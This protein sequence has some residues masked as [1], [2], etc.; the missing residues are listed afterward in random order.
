MKVL[1]QQK[2]NQ[3]QQ[4]ST[5]PVV[6]TGTSATSNTSSP[7][8]TSPNTSTSNI[9]FSPS[10]SN[11]SQHE[12]VGEQSKKRPHQEVESSS[13]NGAIHNDDF[14]PLTKSQKQSQQHTNPNTSSTTSNLYGFYNKDHD[15]DEEEVPTTIQP[16]V[17]DPRIAA[18]QHQPPL[19]SNTSQD[20]KPSPG[21]STSAPSST[22]R[23]TAPPSKV[24]LFSNLPPNCQKSELM[25]FNN[26]PE[27]KF[28]KVFLFKQP[29][30]GG[31][32]NSGKKKKREGYLAFVEFESIEKAQMFLDKFEG[33]KIKIRGRTAY[34]KYSEKQHLELTP[35]GATS[36]SDDPLRDDPTSVSKNVANIVNTNNATILHITFTHCD[37]Y[38]YPMHVDILFNLF[39][40]FGTLEKINIFV[41]NE[42]TQSLIQFSTADEATDALKEMEGKYVFPDMELYRMNIQFS[43]KYR[44]ELSIKENNDRN[45]DYTVFP[46]RPFESQPLPYGGPPY[47]PPESEPSYPSYPDS[48]G[49][50]KQ[51]LNGEMMDQSGSRRNLPS[52]PN[53]P[54]YNSSLP[55]YYPPFAA[56]YNPN[57]NYGSNPTYYPP[58]GMVMP[59]HSFP[60]Q[61][62]DFMPPYHQLGPP[63]AHHGV[64]QPHH[65]HPQSSF[66]SY[67]HPNALPPPVPMNMPPPSMLPPGSSVVIVKGLPSRCTCDHL[68]I[69]FGLYGDVIKVSI[70]L[71]KKDHKTPHTAFIQFKYPHEAANALRF[72]GAPYHP[73]FNKYSGYPPPSMGGSTLFGRTLQIEPSLRIFDI[74]PPRSK[75]GNDS[76]S[77][78]MDVVFRSYENSPLHR[79]TPRQGTQESYR[80]NM[81]KV[82]NICP[83]SPVLHI[84]N[85]SGTT[86]EDKIRREIDRLFD[87]DTSEK[88]PK[89]R[90]TDFKFIDY[91]KTQ[92]SDHKLKEK[93]SAIIE[94]ESIDS[95]TTVLVELHD[96][97]IDS[98][99]LNIKFSNRTGSTPPPPFGVQPYDYGYPQPLDD[100]GASRGR[101]GSSRGHP[102]DIDSS[103]PSMIDDQDN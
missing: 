56:G 67:S 98:H 91:K 10:S 76:N 42:L 13:S 9:S 1:Q 6:P 52:Y 41:K 36:T 15:E 85:I 14:A 4:S 89:S 8:N 100:R 103:A 82:M 12:V 11:S 101:R 54:S 74:I 16:I 39:N 96:I 50:R 81:K 46:P 90:I 33:Q 83:P 92:T 60:P 18:A 70:S 73:P 71:S 88:K 26:F 102:S 53:D 35:G 63:Q 45:R 44:D 31:S 2:L 59:G 94:M 58:S 49:E 93:K 87:Y 61:G 40:K 55:P 38:R 77:S 37:E 80:A 29:S 20:S 69:L 22:P 21:S 43:K 51:P 72:L 23:Q 86:T 57:T 24:L 64:P 25:E 47:Y 3:Q 66:P 48:N 27:C 7:I 28:Q 84:S 34:L 65:G 19:E 99:H 75:P 32:K 68:F 78:K 30:S 5:A 17:T 95:A 97:L 62:G 79:F